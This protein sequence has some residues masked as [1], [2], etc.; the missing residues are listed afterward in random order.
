MLLKCW[1][2]SLKLVWMWSPFLK[3][4]DGPVP[5]GDQ[6]VA[7]HTA[8]FPRRP[9]HTL[10]L[11]TRGAWGLPP[12]TRSSASADQ[13]A[14]GWHVKRVVPGDLAYGMSSDC[15]KSCSAKCPGAPRWRRQAWRAAARPGSGTQS[16]VTLVD[17]LPIP[18]PGAHSFSYCALSVSPLP[19]A[20][21]KRRGLPAALQSQLAHSTSP[22][23]LGCGPYLRPP[24]S[25]QSCPPA[26]GP[27]LPE[28]SSRKAHH[29]C[30]CPAPIF[31]GCLLPHF[32]H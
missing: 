24:T 29:T 25:H 20:P 22:S 32:Q 12:A 31:Q 14:P 16:L 15:P 23:S 21:W 19:S 5:A 28:T 8:G 4:T 17:R 11:A 27:S 30:E 9:P 10:R 1:Y 26:S 7:S 3:D 13:H 6:G 2:M 18:L